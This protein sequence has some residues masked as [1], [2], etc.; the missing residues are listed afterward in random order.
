MPNYVVCVSVYDIVCRAKP[1][2][3]CGRTEGSHIFWRA[4]RAASVQGQGRALMIIG[5]GTCR[6]ALCYDVIHATRY[7][8]LRALSVSW[9]VCVHVCKAEVWEAVL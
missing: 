1:V 5:I 4:V 3:M 7:E 9:C 8:Y 6:C 2:D